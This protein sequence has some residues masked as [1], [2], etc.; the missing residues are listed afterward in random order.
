MMAFEMDLLI[1]P[2][3]QQTLHP[4]FVA[5]TGFQSGC[6]TLALFYAL[7]LEVIA[8]AGNFAFSLQGNEGSRYFS[9]A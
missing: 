9:R 3:L 5:R 2:T 1:R 8:S 6:H 7:D 4:V